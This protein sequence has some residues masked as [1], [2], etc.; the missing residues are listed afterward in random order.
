MTNLA[1]VPGEYSD[2]LNDLLRRRSGAAQ[3]FTATLPPSS[4]GSRVQT[5]GPRARGTPEHVGPKCIGVNWPTAWTQEGAAVTRSHITVRPADE[6]DLPD[7]VELWAEL[8]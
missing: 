5:S 6:S 2:P 8:K 1:G 3:K 4:F 7:V